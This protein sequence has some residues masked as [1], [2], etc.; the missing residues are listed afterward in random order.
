MKKL[1]FV[2]LLLFISGCGT[3]GEE[4]KSLFNA[5]ESPYTGE[6]TRDCSDLEPDNPYSSG[7]GHYAGFEWAERK[8]VSSCGGNSQSFV[9]GCEE[10][11][12]QTEDY[13]NC[14]DQ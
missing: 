11:L 3:S 4:Q 6:T 14:L 7:S 8:D 13:T 2:G 5:Y 10:Y 12:S 9:E 1:L